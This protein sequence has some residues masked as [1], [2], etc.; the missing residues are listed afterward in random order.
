MRYINRCMDIYWEHK[1]IQYGWDRWCRYA[2]LGNLVHWWYHFFLQHRRTIETCWTPQQKCSSEQ[3]PP[4][5][6]GFP[7]QEDIDRPDRCHDNKR[8]C[9]VICGLSFDWVR[10]KNWNVKIYCVHSVLT[11]WPSTQYCMMQ[12]FGSCWG[13]RSIAGYHRSSLWQWYVWVQT[14]QPRFESLRFA[15]AKAKLAN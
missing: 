1:L 4:P 7:K 8:E 2:G 10:F 9:P 3:V 5:S 12:C 11:L 13:T 15:S 6:T 14:Q